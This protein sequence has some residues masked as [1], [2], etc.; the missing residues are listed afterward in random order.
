MASQARAAL[1]RGRDLADALLVAACLPIAWL[2]PDRA[3][4]NLAES[5]AGAWQALAPHGDQRL[6]SVLREHFGPLTETELV[7]RFRMHNVL[8]LLAYLRE[9]AAR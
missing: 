5:L 9:W 3:W 4:R 1:V 8:E 6:A 2:L 7:R